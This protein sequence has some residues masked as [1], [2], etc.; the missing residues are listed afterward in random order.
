M[1][2]VYTKPFYQIDTPCASAPADSCGYLMDSNGNQ[3]GHAPVNCEYNELCYRQGNNAHPT[4]TTLP[5]EEDARGIPLDTSE[6]QRCEDVPYGEMPCH[7]F[8]IANDKLCN[9]KGCSMG[10]NCDPYTGR[11]VRSVNAFDLGKLT[12]L[13]NKS[14]TQLIMMI[15]LIAL[16]FFVLNNKKIRKKLKR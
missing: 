12:S 4:C 3:C 7:V 9:G 10:N 13:D 5:I 1:P 2:L 15:G 14:N 6:Y 16:V 11:C 8:R